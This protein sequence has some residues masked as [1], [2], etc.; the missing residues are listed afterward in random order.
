MMIT[1]SSCK[2]GGSE[3]D[4]MRLL[5]HFNTMCEIICIFP[6]GERMDVFKSLSNKYLIPPKYLFQIFQIAYFIYSK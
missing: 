2:I 4:F 3:D 6:E 5:K 1:H